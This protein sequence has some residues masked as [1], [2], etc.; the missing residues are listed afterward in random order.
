MGGCPKRVDVLIQVTVGIFH[1]RLSLTHPTQSAQRRPSARG[2]C[3]LQF[4]QHPLPTGKQRIAIR[5]VR[6]RH[7]SARRTTLMF[8]RRAYG[9]FPNACF[10]R[11]IGSTNGCC[12][13]KSIPTMLY[14]QK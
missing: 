4:R 6:K 9:G 5:E 11:S 12:S 7:F 10:S 3:L 14:I 2:E 13:V 8:R 1:G